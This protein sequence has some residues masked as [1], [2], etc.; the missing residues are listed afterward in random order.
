[1]VFR[2][3]SSMVLKDSSGKPLGSRSGIVPT[4]QIL[5]VLPTGIKSDSEKNLREIPGSCGG[6][7]P[8]RPSCS[9]VAPFTEPSGSG[10]SNRRRS[11]RIPSSDAH[12]KPAVAP[13]WT[14]EEAVESLEGSPARHVSM[15]IFHRGERPLRTSRTNAA[16][17]CTATCLIA[18]AIRIRV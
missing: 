13:R 3:E 9:G 10:N 18:V 8:R 7:V 14:A 5:R 12:E 17:A 1:M 2:Q 6:V 15:P 4:P 16:P 11:R